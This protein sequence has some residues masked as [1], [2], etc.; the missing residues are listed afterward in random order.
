MCYNDINNMKLENKFIFVLQIN[1]KM[2]QFGLFP[3][4]RKHEVGIASNRRSACC[5]EYCSQALY[6]PPVKPWEFVALKVDELTVR[7]QL[8][9]AR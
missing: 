5:G 2:S 8:I 9:K 7:K 6:T 4:T 1:Q 3:A